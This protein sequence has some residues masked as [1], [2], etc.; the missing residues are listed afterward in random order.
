MGALRSRSEHSLTSNLPP[1]QVALTAAD[2]PGQGSLSVRAR[3]AGREAGVVVAV[4][5]V[6]ELPGGGRPT[7]G[8][9]SP[10]WSTIPVPHGALAFSRAAGRST[11]DIVTIKPSPIAP[12]SSSVI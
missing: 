6:E 12:P 5:V 2:Q 3:A 1:Q 4:E 10:S 7:R 8:F 9:P 11:A